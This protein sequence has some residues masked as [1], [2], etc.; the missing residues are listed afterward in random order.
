MLFTLDWIFIVKSVYNVNCT[1]FTVKFV[2]TAC[3]LH[4]TDCTVCLHCSLI[5]ND[6]TL[7]TI[8]CTSPVHCTL[9]TEQWIW[10]VHCKVFT[11]LYINTALYCIHCNIG[12]H[13]ELSDFHSTHV[14]W[15][16]TLWYSL[17][18][19]TM[20]FTGCLHYGIH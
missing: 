14:Q 10:T 1:L 8:K 7:C 13:S 2:Y 16:L 20:E 19:Y 17:G 6:L 9:I 5:A 15:V 18:A 4:A 12:L 3:A 11:W